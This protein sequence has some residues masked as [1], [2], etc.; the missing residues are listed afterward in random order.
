MKFY[1][2]RSYDKERS[3]ET[4]TRKISLS[5]DITLHVNIIL[6]YMLAGLLFFIISQNALVGIYVSSSYSYWS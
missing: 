6:L 1:R 5:T 2:K 4:I 3:N